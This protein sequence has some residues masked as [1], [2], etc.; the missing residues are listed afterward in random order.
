[1]NCY[2][3]L[4]RRDVGIIDLFGDEQM[5]ECLLKEGHEGE[6]LVH[7]SRGYFLWSPREEF[8]VDSEGVVCDCDWIECYTYTRISEND[9][10]KL[11]AE[12]GNG[13]G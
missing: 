4:P 6:H 11:L 12:I 13:A 1:M 9:A 5:P 10:K 2:H 3:L 8:C 7:T